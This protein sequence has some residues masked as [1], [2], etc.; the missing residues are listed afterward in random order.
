MK[1]LFLLPILSV[2]LLTLNCS[3]NTV[4]GGIE[5]TNGGVAMINGHP[6]EGATVRLVMPTF[7][8]VIQNSLVVDSAITGDDGSFILNREI[9]GNY[10]LQ[11]EHEQGAVVVR[12]FRAVHNQI[13]DLYEQGQLSGR[14][15]SD[16]AGPV[17]L[18]LWGSAYSA[19]ADEN[20]S[21]DFGPVAPGVYK[22][23]A[24]VPL[25]TDPTATTLSPKSVLDIGSAE[26]IHDTIDVS[27]PLTEGLPYHSLGHF[28]DDIVWYT[29]SDSI[30][31]RYDPH[32]AQWII[33][34]TAPRLEGNSSIQVSS[35]P[36]I[37]S[38]G[39]LG[40]IAVLGDE[41]DYPYA[42][43]GTSLAYDYSGLLMNL[44]SMTH[45][46]FN[47]RG[48]G[49][50]RIRFGSDLLEENNGGGQYTYQF[51]LTD[52]WQQIEITPDSL[53][54]TPFDE[55]LAAQY[56]WSEAAATT[57][58]IEFEFSISN[59]AVGDTLILECDNMVF[60]GVRLE[61]LI[62]IP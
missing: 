4:A 10:N 7:E 31:R 9:D 14:V 20:G 52:D 45:F 36:D 24:V 60:H 58:R 47:A 12:G 2:S 19:I 41:Y 28:V 55:D 15:N 43:L 13:I 5:T 51:V 57:N 30:S 35:L 17:R 33:D 42:G 8:G 23:V 61:E 27:D 46:T 34:E 32:S 21:F 53:E 29:F 48:N 26:N 44:S 50:L 25:S 37:T 59:N 6:A 16:L 11:I 18:N 56:P 54:L 38:G 49:V 39:P 22:M 1:L 40:A 3:D 62:E